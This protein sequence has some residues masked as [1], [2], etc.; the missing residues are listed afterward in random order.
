MEI[1]NHRLQPPWPKTA[2]SAKM[3]LKQNSLKTVTV[4]VVR[5]V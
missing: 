3:K 5:T 4:V 2:R 1:E